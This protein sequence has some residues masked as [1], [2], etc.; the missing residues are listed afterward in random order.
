MVFLSEESRIDSPIVGDSNYVFVRE[1]EHKANPFNSPSSYKFRPYISVDDIQKNAI[2]HPLIL[3]FLE[4][5]SEELYRVYNKKNGL[6]T[7]VYS[8]EFSQELYKDTNLVIEKYVGVHHDYAAFDLGPSLVSSELIFV[9]V[10]KDIRK[11]SEE[12]WEQ[13]R[14]LT[15][16]INEHQYENVAIGF[17]RASFWYENSEMNYSAMLYL[18]M[19]ESELKQICRS[20]VCLMIVQNG[21]IT[22][23]YPLRGLPRFETI[24]SKLRL[25]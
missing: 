15:Q 25:E 8:N 24:S 19:D 2:E 17:Q 13:I 5:Y 10:V 18:N 16:K 22:A 9:W 6:E 23:K 21:V 11:I 12:N 3:P 20:N 14:A 4:K 1:K 7:V